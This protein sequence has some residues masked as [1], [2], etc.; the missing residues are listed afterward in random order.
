MKL[1]AVVIVLISGFLCVAY[2]AEIKNC[3]TEAEGKFTRVTVTD[4]D[5]SQERCILK[6]GTNATIT[7]DF[8]LD[9]ETENEVKAVCFGKL[10]ALEVPFK[11]PNPN[12]CKDSGLECPL[13]KNV[14]YTYEASFPILK[15]YPKVN[16]D[17]KY[18][19]KNKENKNIVCVLVPVKIV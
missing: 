10:G 7:I 9:V 19:L 18:E 13:K 17:V 5:E 6:K 4:C 14:A 8:E 16:V 2:C 12:A 11:L 1:S 15:V 3:D